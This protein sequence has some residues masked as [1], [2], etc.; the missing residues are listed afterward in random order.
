L[1]QEAHERIITTIETIG[2]MV[3]RTAANGGEG[4]P[5]T[6]RFAAV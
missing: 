1:P 6:S 2:D 3:T 4:A 5:A